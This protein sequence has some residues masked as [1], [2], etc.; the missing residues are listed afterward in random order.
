MVVNENDIE[1]L[2]RCPMM[3]VER[4]STPEENTAHDVTTWVLRQ[5]F[6]RKFSEDPVKIL[7]DIRG[8]MI[9]SWEGDKLEAG[10]LSRAAAFR[11]L[12]L[13]L[14]YEI[15]HLEQP[16]N[17]ILSGYT[18]QGK[19][20]LLR[21]RKGDRNIIVLIVHTHEPDLRHKQTLPPD[22]LTLSRYLHA[23][24]T[25]AHKNVQVLHYPVLRGKSWFNRQVDATLAREYLDSMLKVIATK[26]IYPIIGSHCTRCKSKR[27]LEVFKNG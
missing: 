23:S 7:H 17:L 21:K 13:I 16:Y 2:L 12:T 10:N 24:V 5:A 27:C 6:S 18:I 4:I 22:P 26:P 8:K 11:L 19:Y 1:R 9:E 25:E 3:D 20:A 15:I 14:D